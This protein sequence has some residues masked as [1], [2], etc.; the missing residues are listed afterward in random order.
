L[1]HQFAED[2][3]VAGVEVAVNPAV[4]QDDQRQPGFRKTLPGREG[5]GAEDHRVA[6]P[7]GRRV[8]DEARRRAGVAHLV[9]HGQVLQAAEQHLIVHVP[10]QRIRLR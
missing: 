1:Q 10:G 9:H 5:V 7:L 3:D 4:D 6:R 2:V 8:F